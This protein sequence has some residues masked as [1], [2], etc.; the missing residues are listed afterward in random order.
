MGKTY[1]TRQSAVRD[2]PATVS[3]GLKMLANG[4]RNLAKKF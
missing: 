2:Y 3:I 1:K 4:G